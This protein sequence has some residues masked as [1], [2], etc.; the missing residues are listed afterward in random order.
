MSEQEEIALGASSNPQV[1]VE[2][3]TYDDPKLQAFINEK[4]QEMAKFLTVPP[5]HFTLKL[6]TLM[7]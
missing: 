5:F 7:L 4:G 6:L 1:L 3:G 2:F